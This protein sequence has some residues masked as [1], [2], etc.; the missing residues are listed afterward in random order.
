MKMI[1][2]S[3]CSQVANWQEV[4]NKIPC[5]LWGVMVLLGFWLLLK[6]VLKP[7]IQNCNDA[8]VR[9]EKFEREKFWKWYDKVQLNSDETLKNEKEVL[10]KKIDELKKDN[11]EQSDKNALLNK[12]IDIYKKILN[13]L[14]VML[15]IE[16]ENNKQ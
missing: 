2:L 13:Q 12:E 4:I 9:K 5:L 14:N 7:C 8:K 16:G 1:L 3:C 15:K 10:E 11:K 6:Y